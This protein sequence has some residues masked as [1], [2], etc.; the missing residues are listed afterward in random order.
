MPC[1]AGDSLSNTEHEPFP[2]SSYHSLI[3]STAGEEK[4]EV[5]LSLLLCFRQEA[6]LF[7]A[8]MSTGDAN[9][10]PDSHCNGNQV[11]AA[12]LNGN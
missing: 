7:R 6:E 9:P 12:D 10:V 11:G 5:I 8:Q 1:T 3:W 2:K 4:K